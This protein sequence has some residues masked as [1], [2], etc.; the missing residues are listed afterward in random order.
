MDES[1][2]SNLSNFSSLSGSLAPGSDSTIDGNGEPLFVINLCAAMTPIDLTGQTLGDLNQY[3]VYQVSRM[4]DGRRRYRLRLGFFT[5]ES[6]AEDV[7]ASVRGRYATAFT[8]RL[9][10]E[11]LKNAA[12]YLK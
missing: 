12:G 1:R 5:T 7:L 6:H 10:E 8:S 9:C 4:E 3:R 2:A 11:D